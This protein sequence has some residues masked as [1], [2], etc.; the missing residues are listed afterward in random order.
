MSDS[1]ELEMDTAPD[2]TAPEKITG[3]KIS[4]HGRII[5]KP[6]EVSTSTYISKEK[7]FIVRV[8]GDFDESVLT[9]QCS[10]QIQNTCQGDVCTLGDDATYVNFLYIVC[11]IDYDNDD[12]PVI[13]EALPYIPVRI[14]A[15]PYKIENICTNCSNNNCLI[16]DLI[17]S[18]DEENHF[19]YGYLT[20][21][22]GDNGTTDKRRPITPF[23]KSSTYLSDEII[24]IYNLVK[25]SD[26]DTFNIDVSACLNI[27]DNLKMSCMQKYKNRKADDEIKFAGWFNC[28]QNFV[29]NNCDESE[30]SLF[31]NK[32]IHTA[33]DVQKY[34]DK[35]LLTD[36]EYED[37]LFKFA[38]EYKRNQDADKANLKPLRTI[39]KTGRKKIGRGKKKKK[40][41]KKR[42]PF[43]KKQ[44]TK[45]KKKSKKKKSKSK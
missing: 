15:L 13:V 35:G 5:D 17:L 30:I 14:E 38:R 28:F 37:Y 25:D 43:K 9:R 44:Q 7:T 29:N 23:N 21:Y 26:V 36:K 6:I 11:G 3:F 2:N 31:L 33:D 19:Y 27:D 4:S 22:D 32:N 40:Q 10:T 41:T 24:N 16:P 20:Y 12:I 1:N 8:R 34:F 39:K 42:K 45:K 18:K